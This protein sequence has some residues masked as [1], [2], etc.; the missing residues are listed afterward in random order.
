MNGIISNYFFK[1][2]ITNSVLIESENLVSCFL[3]LWILSVFQ[4]LFR[5][6]SDPN[7]VLGLLTLWI[8]E[9]EKKKR[10]YYSFANT[11]H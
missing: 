4:K 8:K 10:K 9:E 6:K 11:A 7:C 1:M 3:L 2:M 5:R